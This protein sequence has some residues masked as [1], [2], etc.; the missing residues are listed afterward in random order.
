VLLGF[1]VG[2]GALFCRP[3]QVEEVLRRAGG[4]RRETNLKAFRAGVEQAAAAA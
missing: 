2:S 1:A 3:H 4:R